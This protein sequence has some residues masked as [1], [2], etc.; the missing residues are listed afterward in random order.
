[1]S[2]LIFIYFNIYLFFCVNFSCEN[3]LKNVTIKLYKF[4]AC[5]IAKFEYLFYHLANN[6]FALAKERYEEKTKCVKPLG[7]A[8]YSAWGFCGCDRRGC[9]CHVFDRAV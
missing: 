8:A 2:T 3:Y 1:M 4:I 5:K 7:D 9:T 6:N